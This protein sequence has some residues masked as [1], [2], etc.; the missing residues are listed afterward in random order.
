M[1]NQHSSTTAKTN[2]KWSRRSLSFIS[3]N[4]MND[5]L[6]VKLFYGNLNDSVMRLR[7]ETLKTAH[8]VVAGLWES[9]RDKVWTEPCQHWKDNLNFFLYAFSFSHRWKVVSVAS[10]ACYQSTLGP[11]LSASFLFNT[12]E[13]IID[14]VSHTR[15]RRNIT[16]CNESVEG[17]SSRF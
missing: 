17:S 10:W 12:F 7:H 3:W 2:N 5:K 14:I 4:E 16:G 8:C 6:D 11:H 9:R 15:Q 1:K 13:L